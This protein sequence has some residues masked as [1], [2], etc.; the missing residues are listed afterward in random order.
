LDAKAEERKRREEG[1]L[2]IIKAKEDNVVAQRRK[3]DEEE[4]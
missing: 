3:R 1:R 4:E 2:E